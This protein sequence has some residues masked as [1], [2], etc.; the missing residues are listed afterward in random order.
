LSGGQGRRM[1]GQDKGWCRYQD[2]A[3]I[4]L[5]LQ[6][7]QQQVKQVDALKFTLLISAN[8]NIQDYQALDELIEVVR[9][10]R[11][12]FCGPL[13]GIEA[14]MNLPAN[15][16]VSRWITYPVD[17]LEV[18]KNYLR[19]MAEIEPEK[20]G[21]LVQNGRKHFAH[22]SLPASQKTSI[23]RYLDRGERSI[24]GW[25]Q[26]SGE[27]QKIEFLDHQSTILNMNSELG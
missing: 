23:S 4:Q 15:A 24:K 3:F 17:S 16:E 22:L 1:Q 25:L 9:D 2:Q 12:G 14:A 21:Y 10:Q 26:H 27:A 6:Q 7:L 13:A 11:E 18:P 8:R 19:I 20:I 5:V